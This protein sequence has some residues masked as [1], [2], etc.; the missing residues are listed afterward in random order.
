MLAPTPL[1][2]SDDDHT[3]AMRGNRRMDQRWIETLRR[4]GLSPDSGEVRPIFLPG[5]PSHSGYLGLGVTRVPMRPLALIHGYFL[6]KITLLYYLA[7]F[8]LAS[9]HPLCPVSLPQ[10]HIHLH[11]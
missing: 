10:Y 11:L 8:P 7:R 1:R 2:R 3:S 5:L 4:V 9:G 6:Q